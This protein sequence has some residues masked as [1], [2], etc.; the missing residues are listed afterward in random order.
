MPP[1]LLFPILAAAFLTI[2]ILRIARDR[3]KIS[4]VS[5]TWLTIALSFGLVSGYLW[6]RG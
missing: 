6:A 4:I 2:A 5:R 1:K 3:G